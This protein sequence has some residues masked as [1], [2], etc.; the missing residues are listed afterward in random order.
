MKFRD[1]R[2][3]W[4]LLAEQPGY[5]SVVVLGLSIGFAACFLL[6]GYVRYSLSY[7]AA[8]PQAERIYLI[9]VK[10]NLGAPVWNEP[11]PLPFLDVAQRSGLVESSTV[12]QPILRTMRVGQQVS[13]KVE[14]RAVHPS[15]PAMFGVSAVAGDLS[16]AL[17]RPDMLALTR[18]QARILF[19][20]DTAVGKSV[21]I[22]GKSFTVA[23]LLADPQSNSTM[24]YAA[25][26]G[27][28]SAAW[29]E[30]QRSNLFESWGRMAGGRLYVKL[31]AG[32]AP[33]ALEQVLQQASARSPII[34]QLPP[35]LVKE[36]GSRPLFD[37]R[38]GKLTDIYFDRDTANS[39]G[40]V[41][42]G[43]LV[44]VYGL[45]AV[46][47]LILL[48]A[49][50]NYV[51]LA[52]VRTLR[53]QREIAMRKLQGASV[54][55]LSRQF[56]AE[57]LLVTLI[58]TGGG[59]LLAQLLL[60]LFAD[61]MGRKLDNLV[62]VTNLLATVGIGVAVGLAAGAYPAWVAVH[63]RP[64]QHLSG[65]G[66]SES[67]GAL[68]LRRSLTVVQF[69]AAM[70]LTAITLAI[71]WQT[72]FA[73]HADPGF[74]TQP[75]LVLELPGDP[76]AP[77]A[78]GIRESL[79]R[80][81][82]VSVV[83][84]A[85][86]L[87][88][89]HSFDGDSNYLSRNDGQKVRLPLAGVSNNFFDA[90][91]LRPVAGRL[92]D[93][94]VDAGD[95]PTVIVLN[96]AAAQALGYP[97][98]Q[99]AVGQTVTLGSG[100]AARSMRIVG[101]AP[102]IR[103]ETLRQVP[104]PMVYVPSTPV[105]VLMA[106]T[107]GDLDAIERQVGTLVRQYFPN[108]VVGVRRMDSYYAE[109]YADDVRLAKLLGLS[110]LIAIA[111]A[112]FGIYVLSAY[113]V[114]RLTKQIVLRKLFGAKPAAIVRLLL[115]EFIPVLAIG[116]LIGLPVAAW[117]TLKYLASFVERAPIGGWTLAAALL[118]ALLVSLVS[119]LRQLVVAM[120]MSPAEALRN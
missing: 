110:S 84:G 102:A 37:L 55:R 98:P 72:Y 11:A 5:S 32:V 119:T 95:T 67:R 99:A 78:R 26:T 25:L 29:N 33:A 7:D 44:T 105:N 56:L 91:A 8:V 104:Q 58:A 54:G 2:I 21:E 1:F 23:A 77:P 107:G 53:R 73:S 3:G 48:L 108:E 47:A 63:V 61:L 62:T 64:Q 42:H 106:R 16:A 57:S 49:V 9:K 15:F 88:P 86:D 38:V 81:A 43:D 17:S 66:G 12:V 34:S 100:A 39:P 118:V 94:K 103:Y 60:P 13:K 89:G 31:K 45:A 28:N 82:G 10:A 96:A 14:L 92:F 41:P 6:L 19:G 52:T 65:R 71:A 93:S 50:A 22:D 117:A 87:V 90:F 35:E 83:G 36:L 79:A 97:S 27:I 75:L 24:Q 115:G 76:N 116:A 74:D 20:G 101:I 114:Q 69:A 59:L 4:R 111:I 120:R 112:A 40:S 109:N 51:N 18:S 46:A 80:V 30:A 68:R 113:S 85:L 70:A